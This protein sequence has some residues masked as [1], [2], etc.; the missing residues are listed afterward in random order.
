VIEREKF[1]ASPIV[2]TSLPRPWGLLASISCATL[3]SASG[4]I[5]PSVV[6]SSPFSIRDARCVSVAVST[7]T[8]EH[9]TVAGRWLRD[10]LVD[11]GLHTAEMMYAYRVHRNPPTW[12]IDTYTKGARGTSRMRGMMSGVRLR[13]LV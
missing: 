12:S 3:A 13:S 8:R 4:M 7:F 2:S 9:F 10:V 5:S 11:Q 1:G 6:L